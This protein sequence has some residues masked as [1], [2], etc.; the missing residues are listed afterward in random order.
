MF[1]AK[2]CPLTVIFDPSIPLLGEV[3][4]VEVVA[5]AAYGT[6]DPS[7]RSRIK[8]EAKVATTATFTIGLVYDH[9]FRARNPT[10]TPMIRAIVVPA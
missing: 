3:V 1:G 5:A 6:K 10:I 4:I 2:P 7:K 9:F 8:P